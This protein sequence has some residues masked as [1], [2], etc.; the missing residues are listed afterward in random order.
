MA[1]VADTFV[2]ALRGAQAS[3]ILDALDGEASSFTLER[4]DGTAF[5]WLARVES[6]ATGETEEFRGSDVADVLAQAATWLTLGASLDRP[7][8]FVLVEA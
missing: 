2:N 6:A 7:V 8:P 3:R 5:T 4:G 1:Q